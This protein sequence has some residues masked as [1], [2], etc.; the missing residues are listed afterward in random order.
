MTIDSSESFFDTYSSEGG[1]GAPSFHFADK[2][3]VVKGTVVSTKV[4]DQT[5]FNSNPPEKIPDSKRPGQY[6]KQLVVVLDTNLRNWEGVNP[7]S[8]SIR[9]E[10]G[11]KRPGSEDTG[12]RAIYVKG[13]MIG[14]VGDAVKA[15]TNGARKGVI[16]GDKLGVQLS[17]QVPTGKGNPMNKFTA[18]C[19]AAP[20]GAD[21]F[22]EAENDAAEAKAA[23]ATEKPSLDLGDDDEPPF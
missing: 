2:G 17:E 4:T 9:D 6:K 16:P 7:K 14:A 18:N 19:I 13:W 10:E 22:D 3:D 11:N 20:V 21:L 1:T 5:V 23:T 8:K 15:A 12:A